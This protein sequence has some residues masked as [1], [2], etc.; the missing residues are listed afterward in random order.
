MDGAAPKGWRF[1][2]FE[3]D[4]GGELYQG[5]AARLV[6]GGATEISTLERDHFTLESAAAFVGRALEE[7]N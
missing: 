5:V 7:L 1:L 4:H 2:K 6:G 3:V